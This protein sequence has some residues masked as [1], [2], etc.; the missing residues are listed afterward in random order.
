MLPVIRT[1]GRHGDIELSWQAI[2]RDTDTQD[3]TPSGGR[4]VFKDGQ[5]RTTIEINI[6]DDEV[7]EL[8]EVSLS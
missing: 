7:P 6:V 8:F 3:F 4:I 2:P 5:R 1:E